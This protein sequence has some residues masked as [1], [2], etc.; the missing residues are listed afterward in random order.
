M[1]PSETD[2]PAQ[3]RLAMAD[4]ADKWQNAP[5]WRA[6]PP[7]LVL[8]AGLELVILGAIGA[9]ISALGFLPLTWR[10][11]MIAVLC[12]ALVT[13]LVVTR[14]GL[15]A[16]HRHF[17]IANSI[18]LSRA[19]FAVLLL[20]VAAEEALGS[21]EVLDTA[22]RWGL[23]VAA[24]MALGLDGVDGWVAR[25]NNM[26]SGF[27]ARFDMEADGLFLLALTL[28]LIVAG[29]VGPWVLASGL[30][31]Y[32]FRI[33]GRLWPVLAAPLFRSRRRKAIFGTQA[34]LLIAAIAPPMPAWI[35]Q[36]CCLTGVVLL[37]YSFS[38]D[39]VW[40][41]GWSRR[42]GA[43]LRESPPVATAWTDQHQLP[44]AQRL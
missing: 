12:Y 41:L 17:G 26:T 21:G 5:V 33:A 8:E 39:I 25:R 7:R 32:V 2:S 16:P 14:L 22:F 20:A 30:T 10:G 6:N 35:A 42:S 44:L 1:P 9:T 11:T 4:Y 40:L 38:V 23:T 19:A 31:Y 43:L 15:H 37:L 36:G 24:A 3:E 18:T 27:G 28:I 13:F 34:V 29:I